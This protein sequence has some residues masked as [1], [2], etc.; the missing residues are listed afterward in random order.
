MTS[1][2]KTTRLILEFLCKQG[3]FAWRN[4]VG[5]TSVRGHFYQMG[6]I[7]SSDIFAIIKGGYFLGIEVKT[8]KDKLRPEQIGFIKNVQHMGAGVIVAKD[9]DD[10][11]KQFVIHEAALKVIHN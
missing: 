5:T 9:F 3:I 2:N 10:F 4:S 7:G 11:Q 6:K 8:G 1:T